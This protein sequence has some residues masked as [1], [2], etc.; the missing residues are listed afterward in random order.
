MS[1]H[2][3]DPQFSFAVEFTNER[4]FKRIV[5]MTIL[6]AAMLGFAIGFVT[7]FLLK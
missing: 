5:F 1:R 3:S 2:P 4:Y 6:S 7:G